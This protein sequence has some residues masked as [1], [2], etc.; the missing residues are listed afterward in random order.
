M[1]QGRGTADAAR[2]S[3]ALREAGLPY[4]GVEVHASVASTNGLAAGRPSWT[5]V[6][7]DE[8]TAGRGRLGRAWSTPPG[9]A[10]AVS[11][12]VPPTA[13]PAWLPLVTGLAVR[14]AVREATGV[15]TVLKWPN[16]V[17]VPADGDRKLCGIL[18]ELVPGGV[19]EP[20]GAR[21][22]PGAD[23]AAT[24]ST[25]R[26]GV[27]VGV[28]INVSQTRAELPVGTATSLALAG[29]GG[30]AGEV[31]RESLLVAYLE[32]L[33]RLHRRLG[34][35]GPEGLRRTYA[36]ACATLGQDVAVQ[37][38]GDAVVTGRATGIDAHGRLVLATS[39]GIRPIAAG[40]VVHVRRGR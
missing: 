29:A 22:G 33:A 13:T 38:P 37:L 35:E 16:D 10:L 11:V 39:A 6:V 31:D 9:R 15:E 36:D 14:G 25:T 5:V 40:D 21:P 27:V 32:Q 4:A 3:R 19:A 30:S 17:L 18:C 23:R 1:T 7:A 2:V 8:Q 20:T 26:A 28:G 12:V 34:E 24:G